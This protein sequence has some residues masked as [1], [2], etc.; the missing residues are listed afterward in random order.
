MYPLLLLSISVVAGQ[1]ARQPDPCSRAEVMQHVTTLAADSMLGRAPGS[2]GDSLSTAYLIRALELAVGAFG[3]ISTQDVPMRSEGA[4][5]RNVLATIP[6]ARDEWVVVTAHHDGLG[7]GRPDA[8]G[9]SIYNGANDNAVGVALAICIARNLA[10]AAGRRGV[11][12]ILTAAEERGRLGSRYCAEHPSVELEKI[13][14]AVNLDAIGVTGPTVDFIAYGNG[15]LIGADSLLQSAGTRAGFDL[16]TVPFESTMYWAFDSAELGAAGIPAL[17]IGQ[18]MRLPAAPGSTPPGGMPALRKRYHTPSD[19]VAG[20]WDPAAILRY[21]ELVASV[22]EA[23][24]THTG[25]I[26]LRLPNV[27]QQRP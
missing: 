13:T 25:T 9:D 16:T 20:D 15:M 14:F 22:V 24:R 4:S 8:R 7:V 1:S 10:P 5:S 3:V 19:E 17:T 12:V 26:Q 21:G 2:R 27:Y 23:A 18:G 11:I 6:G